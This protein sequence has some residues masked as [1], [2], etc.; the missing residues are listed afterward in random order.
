MTKRATTRAV[1]EKAKK[2]RTTRTTKA[3][4]KRLP[5]LTQGQLG[6]LIGTSQQRVSQLLKEGVISPRPDGRIDPYRAIPAYCRSIRKVPDQGMARVREARAAQIEL[7]TAKESGELWDAAT[8][9]AVFTEVW[10]TF[11]SELSGV[12]AACTRDLAQRV[13]I[14]KNLADALERLRKRL[15]AAERSLRDGEPL[16]DDDAADAGGDDAED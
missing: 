10:G 8:A 13:V 7:K 6:A 14:E 16:D 1:A 11:R 9:E 4:T 15:E 5:A 12:P 3:A 2:S